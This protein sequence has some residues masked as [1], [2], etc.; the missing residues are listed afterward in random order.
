MSL[1]KFNELKTKFNEQEQKVIK[2]QSD[3]AK[4]ENILSALQNELSEIIQ[5]QKTKL[6]ETGELSADEYVELKQ[7][8]A[9]YKARIEYYQ[10]LNS[11][12]EERLYQAQENLYLIHQ[13][14][15]EEWGK[16]LYHQANVMLE[17]LF[18]E[19]QA[20]LAQIYGYLA[21][22]KRIE[23]SS[24]TGETQEQAVMRYLMEQFEKRIPTD[25]KLDD[26]L[27]I[28]TQLLVDFSPKTPAERHKQSLDKTPKGLAA[29]MQN[30]QH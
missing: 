25:S 23:P 21:Q 16:Y 22:S 11:E 14:L 3:L 30:F 6:E 19:K 29:L 15:N 13:Q 5:R 7:Q 17:A 4:N 20:E 24:L 27:N 1:E 26:E 12:L 28:S 18:N 9:G 10:A 2:A 8:D